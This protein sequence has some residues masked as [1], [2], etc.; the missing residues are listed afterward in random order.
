MKRMSSV[1]AILMVVSHTTTRFVAPI[2]V[3]YAFGTV[4]FSLA[5][6]RYMRSGGMLVPV[7]ATTR[8]RS[9]TSAGFV[10]V[11]GSKWLNM[12]SI[13]TGI[14]KTVMITKGIDPAQNSTHH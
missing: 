7:R 12:G 9:F 4:S 14:T 10:F 1:G 5:F 6:I 3:T 8:S 13:T 11:R 2:P